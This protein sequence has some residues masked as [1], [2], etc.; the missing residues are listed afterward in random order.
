MRV[1]DVMSFDRY[2][3]EFRGRNDDLYDFRNKCVCEDD[4][5]KH[6]LNHEN[7]HQHTNH[8]G[9]TAD[10]DIANGHYVLLSHDYCYYNWREKGGKCLNLENWGIAEL[11]WIPRNLKGPFY[12]K[13]SFKDKEGI[14]RKL[15]NI[16]E[17][18]CERHLR[19]D[20]RKKPQKPN[21]MHG[22]PWITSTSI[23][24]SG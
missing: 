17:Q 12:R 6:R 4:C 13:Y 15:E 8:P 18:D 5:C 1:T 22:L 20:R 19:N 24:Y 7:Y 14:I 16:K 2:H 11:K 9:H 23:N 21:G 10:H 3:R